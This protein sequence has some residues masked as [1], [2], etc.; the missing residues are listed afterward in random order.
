M[1][2]KK[3]LKRDSPVIDT[4]KRVLKIEADA[5]SCLMDKIDNNFEEAV[6]LILESRGKVVVTGMGKSGLIGKKI[7]STLSSTGTPALFLHPA[8]GCHG[9]LG[10][11]VKNDVVIALSNSG[12]TNEVISLLPVIRRMGIKLIAMT[13]E[14]DSTLAKAGDVVLDIGVK[15]EA[16]PFGL[17]PTAS[18]TAALAMGDALAIALLLKRGFKEEDFALLHPAGSIGRRLLK[19]SDLM[20]TGDGLPLVSIDTLMKDAIFEITSKRL[21]ITG[22]TDRDGRLVGVITDG[23]LRRALELGDNI[24]SKPVSDV[25]TRNPKSIDRDALAARALERMEAHAITALFVH[26]GR[27]R[28]I[29]IGIIHIHDLLRAGVV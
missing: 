13:G 24:L 16:C 19:V 18:T 25:M 4:A 9:D 22:V 6:S 14:R 26:D 11:L 10:I 15:E 29:P 27:K 1:Q 8:E 21:G 12:E 2:L 28:D 17:A 3:L 20:H 5:I 7:A 23:D